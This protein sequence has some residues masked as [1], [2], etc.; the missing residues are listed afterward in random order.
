MIKHENTTTAVGG[1]PLERGVGRLAPERASVCGLT[2]C[3]DKAMCVRCVHM[4]DM[5]ALCSLLPEGV[6]WGDPLTPE[7]LRELLPP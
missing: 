3:R 2:E 7:L 4:A 5:D 6:H 1:S